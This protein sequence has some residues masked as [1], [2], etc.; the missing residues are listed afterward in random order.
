MHK[1]IIEVRKGIV[2]AIYST[3]PGVSVKILNWDSID[4]QHMTAEE[5]HLQEEI[6]QMEDIL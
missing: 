3:N 6:K 2:E 1:I 5:K 4:S